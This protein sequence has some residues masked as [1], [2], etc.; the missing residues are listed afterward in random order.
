[1]DASA[2]IQND[3]KV[4]NVRAMTEATLEFG[5]YSRGHAA[6]E[7]TPGGPR[8]LPADAQAGT[9]LPSPADDKPQPGE[10]YSWHKQ[11][12]EIKSLDGDEALCR[13]IWQEV[14]ALGN[15]FIWQLLLSF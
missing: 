1:M 7:L 15:S 5:T 9:Y 3:A 10:C 2:I 8:P 13:R 11:R 4:E 12:S 14:D 6:T